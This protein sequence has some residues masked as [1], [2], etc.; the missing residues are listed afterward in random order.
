MLWTALN[1]LKLLIK[2]E[3]QEDSEENL[4]KI[5]HFENPHQF[6][7]KFERDSMNKTAFKLIM[8]NEKKML[9]YLDESGSEDEADSLVVGDVS[10]L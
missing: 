2:M 1:Q 8:E 7:F 3:S 9:E 6:Y 5:T 10:L 4:I